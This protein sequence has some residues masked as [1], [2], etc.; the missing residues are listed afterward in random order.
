[1]NNITQFPNSIF[2]RTIGEIPA[3]YLVSL[4]YEEQLLWFSNYL[5][6][7]LIPTYNE[8]L[9]AVKSYTAKIDEDIAKINED[10]EALDE[11]VTLRLDEFMQSITTNLT[12]IVDYKIA[13]GEIQIA[14]TDTYDDEN[15]S[16]VLSLVA[17]DNE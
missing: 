4:T 12:D 8:L 2:L 9:N 15:E 11:S 6:K 3:S 14:L 10:M 13:H 7:T 17:E 5:E 16:L 1:M